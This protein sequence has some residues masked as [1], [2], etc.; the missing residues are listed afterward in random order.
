MKDPTQ[1][2][3]RLRNSH[4]ATLILLSILATLLTPPT[5]AKPTLSYDFD[6]HNG[7]NILVL[8]TDSLFGPLKDLPQ[9]V[10]KD[11][12]IKVKQKSLKKKRRA[13][14]R[15]LKKEI[16]RRRKAER[17]LR[18]EKRKLKLQLSLKRK[19]RKLFGDDEEKLKLKFLED[20][21]AFKV[22]EK[23]SFKDNLNT[24]FKAKVNMKQM[25]PKVRTATKN[26]EESLAYKEE[27]VER[28]LHAIDVH[29]G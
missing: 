20:N 1:G 2:P 7:H 12:D 6:R 19:A 28:S 14:A 10:K 11:L 17:K 16:A 9:D 25:A 18:K 29:L 22:M 4:P 8:K 24:L 13:A 21:Q 15:N 27:I 26:F 23:S 5:T 3:N